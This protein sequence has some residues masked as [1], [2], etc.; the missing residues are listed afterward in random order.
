MKT[1]IKLAGYLAIVAACLTVDRQ[2]LAVPATN[3]SPADFPYTVPFELGDAKF[4][5]GDSITITELRGTR[6]TIAPNESYC[7]AGTY[8]LS[9]QDEASLAFFSTVPHSGSTRVDPRQKVRITKGAGT[10]RLIKTVNEDGYLHLSLYPVTSGSDFGGVYFGQGD[11]VLRGKGVSSHADYQ[12]SPIRANQ[13]LC[14]Y[15]GDAVAPPPNLEAAYSRQGL[16][17]AVETAARNAGVADLQI[18][19]ID[20]SEFPFL[21]SV[22]SKE[23][24]FDK[25]SDQ[26]K[27][28]SGYEYGGSV[29][30]HTVHA[31]N[32]VP[33]RVFPPDAG[34]RIGRRLTIREQM[35][36]DKI[37]SGQ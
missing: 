16:L 24:E 10:F 4:A 6:E 27:K 35:F 11:W 30:S 2:A 18:I 22:V 28:M 33:W 9:S 14:D 26:F 23:G 17:G 19:E 31:F 32:I 29:G 12:T 25:I 20:D 1:K 34:Q 8:I 13:T 5:P 21:I 3:D 37:S 36:F 15:L 7:V